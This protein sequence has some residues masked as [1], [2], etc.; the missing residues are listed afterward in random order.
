MSMIGCFRSASDDE[1]EALIRKPERIRQVLFNDFSIVKKKPGFLARLLGL[2]Y[3]PEEEMII[4]RPEPGNEDFDIDKAW[5]GIHFLLCGDAAAG[6]G[7]L[8]FILD[9]GTYIGKID[10]G[11]GPARAFRKKELEGIVLALETID[12]SDLMKKCDKKIF[13]ANNIYPFIWDEPEDESFGYLISYF[14]GLKTFLRRTFD[15]D[16][17]MLVYIA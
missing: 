3:E 12:R 10:V 5:H 16:K 7:V 2:S 11:Y 13:K 6:R 17:G 9:G 8:G 1:I 4:W 14:E 15:S